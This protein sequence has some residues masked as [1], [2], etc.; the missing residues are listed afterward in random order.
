MAVETPRK[1]QETKSKKRINS[2]TQGFKYLYLSIH[3]LE[4]KQEL[5]VL[6]HRGKFDLL[7]IM[8]LLTRQNKNYSQGIDT[9]DN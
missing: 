3:N 2:K 9:Q 4:D 7:C 5:E 6:I 1:S 8:K